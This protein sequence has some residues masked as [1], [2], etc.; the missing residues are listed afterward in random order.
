[1]ALFNPTLDASVD[2]EWDRF[3]ATSDV[4]RESVPSKSLLN[5]EEAELLRPPSTELPFTAAY[6]ELLAADPRPGI[7][8][9]AEKARPHVSQATDLYSRGPH[10]AALLD[11][12]FPVEPAHDVPASEAVD[13]NTM[14]VSP[15]VVMSAPSGGPTT[16]SVFYCDASNLGPRA[17]ALLARNDAEHRE[18]AAQRVCEA[19]TTFVA[20]HCVLSAAAAIDQMRLPDVRLTVGRCRVSRPDDIRFALWARIGPDVRVRLAPR[21]GL[22]GD[23]VSVAYN[24]SILYLQP[25]MTLHRRESHSW[26]MSLAAYNHTHFYH[27]TALYR[28]PGNTFLRIRQKD[29][30]ATVYYGPDRTAAMA[31]GALGGIGRALTSHLPPE[32]Y[33]AGS[34]ERRVA[35]SEK[36]KSFVTFASGEWPFEPGSPAA[37]VVNTFQM[38][39]GQEFAGW[40]S[41]L[42]RDPASLS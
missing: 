11:H 13:I 29:S 41:R 18:A 7:R 26:W 3:F 35:Y 21:F 16:R 19:V 22:V 33:W 32:F 1:M 23:S 4:L 38:V 28:R 40:R 25:W 8:V 2:R 12:R 14:M 10:L 17:A 42:Q 24:H 34:P 37:T 6:S 30:R 15:E 31:R 39:L 5:S 36:L 27:P 9:L 20:L